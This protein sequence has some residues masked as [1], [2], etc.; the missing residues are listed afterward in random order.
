VVVNG[1]QIGGKLLV[2]GKEIHAKL[3]SHGGVAAAAARY[4]TF[5]I[6]HSSFDRVMIDT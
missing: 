4:S 2:Y 5:D 1:V 6:R 3:D